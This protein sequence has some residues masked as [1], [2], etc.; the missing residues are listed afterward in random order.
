MRNDVA[1]FS[2]ETANANESQS[3]QPQYHEIL[4]KYVT[5]SSLARRKELK[6]TIK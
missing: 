3:S 4:L 2:S 1:E 6:N 5:Q